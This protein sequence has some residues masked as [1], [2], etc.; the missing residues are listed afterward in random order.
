MRGERVHDTRGEPRGRSSRPRPLLA[1]PASA[2]E[3]GVRAQALR[4]A[5]MAFWILPEK[6]SERAMCGQEDL[7]PVRP[8]IWPWRHAA[9]PPPAATL[10]SWLLLALSICPLSLVSCWAPSICPVVPVRVHLHHRS[11][12]LP[13]RRLSVH[14][15]PSVCAWGCTS[16]PVHGQQAGDMHP[17]LLKP[18]RWPGVGQG[19]DREPRGAR[20]P[21]KE[22][23]GVRGQALAFRTLLPSAS[24]CTLLH[25]AFPRASS[26]PF[27]GCGRPLTPMGP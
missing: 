6:R 8:G 5:G 1:L 2:S 17:A 3:V 27:H 10:S 13:V 21:P 16:S 26:H 25:S 22:S 4:G 15:R 12:H 24:W 18:L 7:Q 19:L 20:G 23:W 14:P 11:V 9:R